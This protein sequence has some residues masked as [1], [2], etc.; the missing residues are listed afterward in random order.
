MKE[1][2]NRRTAGNFLTDLKSKE[3]DDGID[4]DYPSVDVYSLH[5]RSDDNVRVAFVQDGNN[6][7][8][9]VIVTPRKV[10]DGI[11]TTS[12]SNEKDRDD[13]NTYRK[14]EGVYDF[15]L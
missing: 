2:S 1:D 12:M 14:E 13:I 6:I 8:R 7:G 4:L 15:S 3:N 11:D 10:V 9:T 5:D